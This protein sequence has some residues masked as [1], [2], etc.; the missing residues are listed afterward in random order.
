MKATITILVC[1]FVAF[2]CKILKNIFHKDGSVL[3]GKIARKFDKD[4]L[5]KIKYPKYVVVVT[6]SSGKGSTVNMLAHILK[7]NNKKIVYNSNGSNVNTAIIT[8]VLKNTNPFTHKLD[9]DVLL[10]E[11]DERYIVNTFKKGIITHMLITNVTRDQPARNYHQKVIYDKIISSFDDRV[12]I[13]INVDDPL[14]NRIRFTH[15]GKITTYGVGKTKY[16]STTVPNYAVDFAYCPHCSTKLKYESYHYGD[17]GLYSCP[18]CD[19]DRGTPDYEA[20]SVNLEESYFKIKNLKLKL[21]KKVFFAV[22]YTLSAYTIA[23]TIGLSEEEI[24]KAINKKPLKSKRME[25]YDVDGRDFETIE[26]KNENALSYLQSLNYITSQKGKKTIIMGFDNVSRRYNYNDLSWL[27][28]VNF[29]LLNND[30]IDKIFCIGRFRYDVATRLNY[31]NIPKNKIVLVDDFNNLISN[32]LNNS[33]GNIYSMVCFDM[34]ENITK[35]IKERE[36]EKSN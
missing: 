34:T 23:R 11:M 26:S 4:I 27:W 30:D 25:I 33:K 16:D 20:S 24:D 28:D 6:G 3:P 2:G 29:E 19:F 12:H 35:L 14:L 1:K 15:K 10:L 7:V 9:A 8:T 5:S 32:V 36:N 17:L 31:A 22:Y 18:K 21:D 13:I